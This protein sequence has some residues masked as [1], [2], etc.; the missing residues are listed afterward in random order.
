M[1]IANPV[2]WEE[3]VQSLIVPMV[4]HPEQV[5]IAVESTSNGGVAIRAKVHP[6]DAGRVI[7]SRGTT[8]AAIAQIVDFAGKRAGT[9]ASITLAD[10]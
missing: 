4:G 10:G 7:G 6:D 8:L 5:A 2:R 3:L 9:P 1:N